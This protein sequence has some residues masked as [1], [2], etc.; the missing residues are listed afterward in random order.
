MKVKTWEGSVGV[1]QM[2]WSTTDVEEAS[3]ERGRG[4][5]PDDGLP[6]SVSS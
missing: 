5:F 1:L 4:T 2:G 6:T 3:D